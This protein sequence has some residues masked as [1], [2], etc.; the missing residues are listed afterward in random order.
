MFEMSEKQWRRL[1]NSLLVCLLLLQF[2]GRSEAAK[3]GDICRL[4]GKEEVELMGLG[5]VIGLQGTGDGGDS[6]T[7]MRSLATALTLMNNPIGVP[8]LK[9][10]DNVAVVM[11]TATI[12]ATGLRRGQHVDCHVSSI[13]GAKS[14]RG[15]R[16]LAA[17][18]ENTLISDDQALA[19][20]SGGIVI[21]DEKNLVSGKIP[22]GVRLLQD[23][24][25]LGGFRLGQK[26]VTLIIDKNKADY[27]TADA[28]A[29]KIHD[30]FSYV[31]MSEFTDSAQGEN[32]NANFGEYDKWI[33]ITETTLTI[34]IPGAYQEAPKQFISELLNISVENPN[35][36]ARVIVN[37]STKTIIITG[38]VEISPVA[39]THKNMININV[40]GDTSSGAFVK[41]DSSNPDE[42]SPQLN[43]LKRAL[44]L[45]Q[46]PAEDKIDIIRALDASGKLNATL[47]EN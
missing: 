18:L 17:P 6:A 7:T 19:K 32:Q 10:A 5:L 3:V 42:Q 26:T 35:S 31:R 46:V 16:L 44:D 12:P 9:D 45:L 43:E 23:V 2:T 22:N 40:G 28:I 1:G 38:E 11:I 47:I 14:L 41:I 8:D 21:E 33:D 20:A 37:N 29:K 4:E 30:T 27:R 15:G 24:S 36:A 13:L 34:E 39:I 25:S